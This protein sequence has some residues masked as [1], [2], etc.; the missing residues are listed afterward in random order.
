MARIAAHH[1][2]YL[3]FQQFNSQFHI[4]II[5]FAVKIIPFVFS[6]TDIIS[7][8]ILFPFLSSAI[9]FLPIQDCFSYRLNHFFLILH[10]RFL[11]G[12]LRFSGLVG[13]FIVLYSFFKFFCGIDRDAE[14][15]FCFIYLD[16][17]IT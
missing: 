9:I 6:L 4:S 7:I 13:G 16:S 17:I 1:A 5:G 15:E 8:L 3:T 12:Y 11:L 2:L 14:N 10:L